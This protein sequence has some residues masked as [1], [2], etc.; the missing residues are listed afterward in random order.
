MLHVF[1]PL[2]VCVLCCRVLLLCLLRCVSS[3]T[4]PS[5]PFIKK[6]MSGSRSWQHQAYVG[7]HWSIPST[8][9][10]HMRSLG[11]CNRPCCFSQRRRQQ[12]SSENSQSSYKTPKLPLNRR[13]RS[14]KHHQRTSATPVHVVNHGG[15][16]L[17]TNTASTRPA[18]P[19]LPV[20]FTCPG[21]T[22][23]PTPPAH[24]QSR[25]PPCP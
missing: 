12:R 18:S 5:H 25:P 21:C 3:V 24:A 23:T 11:L 4:T 13:S 6:T 7:S 9:L 14:S 16:D 8:H 22:A 19:R 2:L 20:C 10:K 1:C 15:A 17:D